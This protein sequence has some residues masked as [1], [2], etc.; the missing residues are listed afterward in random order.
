MKMKKYTLI[1]I[2]SASALIFSSC[3]DRSGKHRG[4]DNRNDNRQSAEVAVLP[5]DKP[6]ESLV[7]D[8][9]DDM[10]EQTARHRSKEDGLCAE[11]GPSP[12]ADSSV[13][14]VAEDAGQTKETA[15]GKIR[16][17]DSRSLEN[18]WFAK[19]FAK[20]KTLESLVADCADRMEEL[21]TLLDCCNEDNAYSLASN[22]KN[23]V[24]KTKEAQD[25]LVK[26]AEKDPEGMEK[27]A[28]NEEL[29]RKFQKAEAHLMAA[30]LKV[31]LKE[32]YGSKAL[33]KALSEQ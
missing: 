29:M 1:A 22:V 3:S 4:R 6:L 25:E 15:A 19:T 24:D 12:Q 5:D 28:E 20:T 30:G 14:L 7:E 31:T 18:G 23:L 13:S 11:I 10:E 21:A 8:R 26:M 9:L 33:K 32:C 2:L 16:N 27:I 17:E